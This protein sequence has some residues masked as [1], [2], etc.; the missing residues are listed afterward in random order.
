M[1][2]RSGPP[3]EKNILETKDGIRVGYL[4][5]SSSL[6]TGVSCTRWTLR[7][8]RIIIPASAIATRTKITAARETLTTV[9]EMPAN[10][11]IMKRSIPQ[12][13]RFRDELIEFRDILL[14]EDNR[15]S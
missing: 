15:S 7:S 1:L 6:R 8:P 11:T 12:T 14:R 13:N 5:L 4:S 2:T 9:A 3:F 10:P